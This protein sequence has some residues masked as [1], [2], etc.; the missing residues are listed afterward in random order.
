[1][2]IRSCR[3]KQ[4]PRDEAEYVAA[5]ESL[6]ARCQ[7]SVHLV[8]ESYGAVPDGPSAKVGGGTAERTGGASVAGA[9]ACKR[10]I[11]LPQGTRSEQAPQQAFIEALHQD[12]EAQ[13]GADLITG[14]I[15][16]SEDRDP[17]HLKEIEKP[18]PRQPARR[19]ARGRGAEPS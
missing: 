16:D 15:E 6:L 7:L 12:A 17:R 19:Q 2:A 5:V 4:L 14:D 9:T 13:F 18:E 3:I 1:M 10:L 8:G 11:W